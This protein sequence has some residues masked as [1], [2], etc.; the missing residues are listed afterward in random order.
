MAPSLMST[1][2]SARLSAPTKYPLRQKRR[3]NSIRCIHDL[4]HL[5]VD[6]HAA[7]DV[8]LFAAQA[9]LAHEVVD[10]VA[11]RLAGA[12]VEV[13]AV[14]GRRI[15]RA[16]GGD[17]RAGAQLRLGQVTPRHHV[18]L[19]RDARVHLDRGDADFAVALCAVRIADGKNAICEEELF[20]PRPLQHAVDLGVPPLND[21]H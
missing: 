18:E 17:A 15:A 2:L 1:A 3:N 8:S 11:H 10:H 13:G 12:F 21:G 14:R 19:E 16:A 5:E 20:D 7:Q 6:R 4:A 9:P